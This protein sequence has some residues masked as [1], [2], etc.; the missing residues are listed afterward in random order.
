MNGYN[1][2]ANAKFKDIQ[3]QSIDEAYTLKSGK[4]TSTRNRCE[5]MTL[6]FSDDNAKEFQL[7]VRVFDDGAAF[8]YGFPETS[9]DT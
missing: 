2:G 6:T 8:R 9:A 1:Y 3:R 5:E 7:I 4:K